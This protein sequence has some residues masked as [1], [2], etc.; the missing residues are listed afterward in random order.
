MRITSAIAPNTQGLSRR[1]PSI[2]GVEMVV[3][4]SHCLNGGLIHTGVLGDTEEKT[5]T[6]RSSISEDI[7]N[8]FVAVVFLLFVIFFKKLYICFAFVFFDLNFI[9]L[10]PIEFKYSEIDSL[11]NH[12]NMMFVI[13]W[14]SSLYNILPNITS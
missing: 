7:Y 5:A 9:C 10:S 1:G 4:M 11:P 14:G 6:K 8:F 12:H 13:I 3:W 2:S